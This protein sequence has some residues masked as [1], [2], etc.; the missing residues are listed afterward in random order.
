MIYLIQENKPDKLIQI[1]DLKDGMFVRVAGN[2]YDFKC[3]KRKNFAPFLVMQ[4]PP[5]VIH[6]DASFSIKRSRLKISG[7][8]RTMKILNFILRIKYFLGW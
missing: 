8:D 4:S 3:V 1:E 2:K 7:G 5:K 6:V